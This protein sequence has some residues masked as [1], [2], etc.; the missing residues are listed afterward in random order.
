MFEK[1]IPYV[2]C[3]DLNTSYLESQVIVSGWVDRIRDHGSII[4][5]DLRDTTN[6]L[7]LVF[8]KTYKTK[9]YDIAEI[10]KQEDVIEVMGKI[11]KRS[12]NMINKKTKNG[13]IELISEHIEILNKS[14]PLPFPVNDTTFVTEELRL[15]YR[16][17]DLRRSG[18][19][20]NL[21]KRFKLIH[22]IRNEL[23]TQGFIEIETP[24]LNKS[25][26]EGA[27][28]FL[29]PSRLSPGTFYALPQ[30]PQIFKQILMISGFEKY[31]QIAKCFRDED[32]R[33]D[34]QPEFT[35]LDIEMSFV[36]KDEI[37]K[38]IE[39]LLSKVLNNVYD[40]NIS[41]P[42]NRL[43]YDESIS[44]FGSDKP[45]TRFGLKFIDL[46]FIF[47]KIDF[48][49][50]KVILQDNGKS[51]GIRIKNSSDKFSRKDLDNLILF[52]QSLKGKGLVWIKYENSIFHSNIK[53]FLS[54]IVKDS[55]KQELSL[56][57]K[58]ILFV[59][60]EKDLEKAY[61][62]LGQLRLKLGYHLNLI[63]KNTLSFTWVT[64][65]PLFEYDEKT[66][67]IHSVH[68]PFTMPKG[69]SIASSNIM[70]IRSKSYDLI[71]NGQEIGGGSIRIHKSDLQKEIL[72]LLG[73]NKK[74]IQEKFGFLLDALEYG[75][76]PHGGFALG[77]DRLIMILQKESSIREVIAFPK[78][79]K[80]SCLMTESPNNVLEE[81]LK[82]LYIHSLNV[83]KK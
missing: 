65:F 66:K 48:N 53:N 4:F 79:Q 56:E 6:Y 27:R 52:I 2:K 72:T 82:D 80:G 68:H 50:F 1:N 77:L 8:D 40:L 74:E 73:I 20:E 10:L 55:L 36:K 16:Y 51:L 38:T 17:L 34:R 37:I 61:Y 78:T 5:V 41:T 35:Q 76:P 21:I 64:D 63:N 44:S 9:I 47:K 7:Q 25:T 30:S 59:I 57:E 42:F 69:S 11:V 62:L 75:T 31:Y 43:T 28:D 15:K 46:T 45:D 26:P 33:S 13:E 58:D 83:K 70:N 54:P 81:Q 29:I 67:S 3:K 24:I 12:N 19:K 22:S 60:T 18:I 49:V 39:T 71:L 23:Y 14:I 32:L